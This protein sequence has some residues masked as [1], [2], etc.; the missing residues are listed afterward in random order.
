[1]F[2]FS[3]S[4]KSMQTI[5]VPKRVADIKTWTKAALSLGEGTVVSVNELSCSQPDCP[6]KQV[7]VLILSHT[8]PLRTFAIH[9][10]LL[11]TQEGD[12]ESAAAE[13]QA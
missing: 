11:D 3:T 5:G 4:E 9:K 1:M 7:V 6:P 12:V 10:S 2:S 13:M 8:E